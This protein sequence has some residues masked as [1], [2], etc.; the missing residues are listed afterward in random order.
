M[1]LRSETTSYRDAHSG[2]CRRHS[3]AHHE[4]TRA[5]DK[6]SSTK[7]IVSTVI[8][9]ML[10]MVDYSKWDNLRDSD[11][12]A[13]VP[14]KSDVLSSSPDSAAQKVRPSVDLCLL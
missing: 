2:S 1:R 7:Q 8:W 5:C 10:A 6:P 14:P 4:L 12:D 13:D 3:H 11:D 9:Q